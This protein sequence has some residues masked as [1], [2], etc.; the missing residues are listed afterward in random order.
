MDKLTRKEENRAIAARNAV[1][2][3]MNPPRAVVPDAPG[4]DEVKALVDEYNR[5]E[6]EQENRL[7]KLYAFMLNRKGNRFVVIGGDKWTNFPDPKERGDIGMGRYV[8]PH[9]QYIS[10]IEPGREKEE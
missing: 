10:E 9:I 7:Q 6:Q 4:M 8:G 1:I 3:R 2:E 5:A